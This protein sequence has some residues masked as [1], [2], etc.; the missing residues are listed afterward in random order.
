M[1]RIPDAIPDDIYKAV[2]RVNFFLQRLWR[3]ASYKNLLKLDRVDE[4]NQADLGPF[5]PKWNIEDK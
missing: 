2:L 3:W 1:K 4:A 5:R